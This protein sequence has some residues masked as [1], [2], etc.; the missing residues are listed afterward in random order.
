[1]PPDTPD[2]LPIDRADPS[3][4]V[5]PPSR[6]GDAVRHAATRLGISELRPSQRE[7]I[8]ASLAGRDVL[9][10][11]PTGFGKSACYQV[12]SML[13]RR[14]VVV[15]SPLRALLRDQQLKLEKRGVPCIRLDGTLRGGRRRE[16][17]ARITSGEPVLAMTTPETLEADDVL[18]VLAETGI[19]LA[20]VDEA[21][22]ISEWGHDFRPSYSRIGS[23]LKKLGRPPLLALTATATP[24]VR[25]TITDSLGMRDH[26]VVAA[27]PHRSNLSFEVIPCEGDER[28]RALIRLMKRLRRPGIIYCATRRET[29]GV[30]ALL[31]RFGVPAYRYHGKMTAKERDTQQRRFM[32]PRHRG[33]MVATNAFGLGIDKRDIRYI[34]HYQ[35]PASLEQ[36]VQEA[37]RAGRD[38][39]KAN[40]ILM[41]DPTDRSI[42][43][44]LLARSRVRPDQLYRLGR[45]LGAWAGEGRSPSLEALAVS[46]ELGPRIV[47]ALL[48]KLE[49]AGLVTREKDKISVAVPP[50]AIEEEARSLAGQFETLRTQDNRRLDALGVYARTTDCR[51]SFLREYFG[52]EDAEPCEL[53]DNCEQRKPRSAGFFAPIRAPEPKK[54]VKP[55]RG[56]RSKS[57]KSK[58]S[59]RKRRPRRKGARAKTRRKT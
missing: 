3:R 12:P 45:A 26:A 31:R 48:V 51:A 33:I 49:E 50:D 37:G 54:N 35:A 56:R 18:P 7:A 6:Q 13:L 19:G 57:D 36:Y 9:M 4:L 28:L 55:R 47:S 14:P 38:G 29:D 17:L 32:R 34:L 23:L 10:I 8:E 52:E 43:E 53:C 39:R 46:A 59:K 30:H 21:H 58:K 22:C 11:L 44:A 41:A 2:P 25:T 40:C 27:S 15:V 1:V 20:A 24:R 16:A 42:H 5:V